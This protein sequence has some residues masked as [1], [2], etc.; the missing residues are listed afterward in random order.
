MSKKLFLQTHPENVSFNPTNQ[1]CEPGPQSTADVT[2]N[3]QEAPPILTQDIPENNASNTFS[4]E[5]ETYDYVASDAVNDKCFS[6]SSNTESDF[7]FSPIHL[8]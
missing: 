3:L 2:Q 8:N 1:E 4:F 5:D 6:D 7:E